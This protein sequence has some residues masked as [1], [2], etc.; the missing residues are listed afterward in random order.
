MLDKFEYTS[1]SEDRMKSFKGTT[2]TTYSYK[3]KYGYQ[4]DT[5]E[6]TSY[7]SYYNKKEEKEPEKKSSYYGYGDDDEDERDSWKRLYG[8]YNY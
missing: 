6:K 3:S 2:S 8:Y 1:V 5:E 4:K 7:L